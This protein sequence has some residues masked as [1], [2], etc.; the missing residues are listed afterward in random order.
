MKSYV[1]KNVI[2]ICFL[3]SIIGCNTDELKDLGIK[4]NILGPVVKT[5]I[6]YTDFEDLTFG[7][8]EYE[9]GANANLSEIIQA[10]QTPIIIPPFGP[11]EEPFPSEFLELGEYAE[12]V[13]IDT[14]NIEIS[15]LNS[16]PFPIGKDTRIVIRDEDDTSNVIVDHAILNDVPPDERY[17]F[18]IMPNDLLVSNTLEIF[19][20]DFQSPG[21]EDTT[22][23]DEN[24]ELSILIEVKILVID[25]AEILPDKEYDIENTSDFELD[26]DTNDTQAYDGIL[27]FKLENGFPTS[28]D[29]EIE[30]LDENDIVTFKFFSDSVRSGVLTIDAGATDGVGNVINNT[31]TGWFELFNLNNQDIQL[32]VDGKKMRVK[33]KFVT[34]DGPDP[35]YIID[36]ESAVDLVITADLTIDVDKIDSE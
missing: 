16:F 25:R 14:A 7:Q 24:A 18:S 12:R 31:S 27:W 6:D 13:L 33:G 32:L 23:V 36:R 30:I 20:V 4:P 35:I 8:T 34:P 26:I 17:F 9:I 15:F 29:L 2:L 28:I 10:F 1:L 19:V 22:T 3:S 11:I 5:T 21:T